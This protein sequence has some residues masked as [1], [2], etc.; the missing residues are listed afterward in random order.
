MNKIKIGLVS[1]NYF[2]ITRNSCRRLI[3]ISDKVDRRSSITT[4]NRA[5]KQ[6]GIHGRITISFLSIAKWGAKF[7]NNSQSKG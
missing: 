1:S 7:K 6:K 4:F 3:F 5:S 2:R